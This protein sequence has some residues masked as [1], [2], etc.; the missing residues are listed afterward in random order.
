[1]DERDLYALKSLHY[2]KLR[3]PRNHQRSLWLNRQFRLIIEKDNDKNGEFL[4]V[5]RIE[6]SH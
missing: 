2:E 5:V 3:G 4:W 6:D 1:M